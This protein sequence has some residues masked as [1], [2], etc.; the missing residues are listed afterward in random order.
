MRNIYCKEC[1]TECGKCAGHT[2]ESSLVLLARRVRYD[3]M[4]FDDTLSD[5][6]FVEDSISNCS[7][8]FLLRNESVVP[9]QRFAVSILL[10]DKS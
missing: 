2:S 7:C 1:Y 10:P 3:A 9:K 4:S 5:N 8:S 6:G